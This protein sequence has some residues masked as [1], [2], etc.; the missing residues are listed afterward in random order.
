MD[1]KASGTQNIFRAT[2]IHWLIFL[3]LVLLIKAG[4]FFLDHLPK[5][6][7]GDS[8]TYIRT[9]LT[10]WIPPDRSFVYGFLLGLIAV[11]ARSLTPL[12]LLQVCLSALSAVILS[13]ILIRVL[14]IRPVVGFAMGLLC[15]LEPMQL[16]YERFILTPSTALFVFALYM[17]LIFLYLRHVRLLLLPAIQLVAVVLISLRMSYFPLF[18][19]M[20]VILPFLVLPKPGPVPSATLS[21]G[22][23][24]LRKPVFFR[25]RAGL[26]LL[27]LL[28]SLGSAYLLTLGYKHVNGHL[29]GKPPALQYE[30]GFFLLADFSPLIQPEDFP[31]P[32]LRDKVFGTLEFDLRERKFRGKHRWMPGGLVH[33][34]KEA[35]PDALEAEKA[36][37]TTVLNAFKRKPFE[38]LLLSLKSW[39]DHLDARYLQRFMV[40]D[41]GGSRFTDEYLDMLKKTFSLDSDYAP[42]AKTL[43]GAYFFHTR[44]W[45]QGLLFLPFLALFT[46]F[47]CGKT[48]RPPAFMLFIATSAIICTSV[49]LMDSPCM[50]YIMPAAWMS[51]II[52]GILIDSLFRIRKTRL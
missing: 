21:S 5:F 3:S 29:S 28:L 7:L 23:T 30:A 16:L 51:F 19:I 35:I 46:I 33:N 18:L 42:R 25:S 8:A 4:V 1:K 41:L 9:A 15:A 40:G 39:R 49:T 31:R 43:T 13:Y 20:T 10:G 34:V 38:F 17:L 52:F 50:R 45:I 14:G 47:I 44:L 36:A 32:G 6:F 2:G 37:R 48:I 22:R 24:V 11:P 12:L 27:H 26:L